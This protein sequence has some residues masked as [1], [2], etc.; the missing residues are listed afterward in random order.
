[1]HGGCLSLIIRTTILA[2]AQTVVVRIVQR[3]L[4]RILDRLR[5]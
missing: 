5:I 2:A 4:Q 1:M 3:L